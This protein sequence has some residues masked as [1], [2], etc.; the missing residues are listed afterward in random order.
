MDFQTPEEAGLTFL[1]FISMVIA[2]AF[3]ACTAEAYIPSSQFVF[4]RVAA[5]HGKGAYIIDDEVSIHEGTENVVIRENWL[6]VDGGEMRLSA[7]GDGT[8]VFRIMKRQRLFWVD[9]SG[10]ERSSEIPPNHVMHNIMMRNPSEQKRVFVN[11]GVLPPEVYRDRKL[12]KEVKDIKVESEP[13]VRLGR[14]GGAVALAYGRPSTADGAPSPGLWIEQ[15][16]FNIRK[17]RGPDGSEVYLND[18]GNYS[19]GLVFPKNQVINFDKHTAS[20][21][22]LKIIAINMGGEYN[23]QFDLTWLRGKPDARSV[24]PQSTL[25]PVVQEFYKRFR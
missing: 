15:D 24:W 21:R 1:L 11:W 20:V 25:G 9:D 22:V 5:Q 16:Q 3:I 10:S 18:Y 4:S 14:V 6:V 8:R 2:A 23:R 13:F 17:M 7:F 19:K 12:P